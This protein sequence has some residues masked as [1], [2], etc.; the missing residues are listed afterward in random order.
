LRADFE[1][2][3]QAMDEASTQQ[4]RAWAGLMRAAQDG[5]ASAYA[6][7][8]RQITPFIRALARR[9]LRDDDVIEDA[10]QDVL[11][12]LHR[13]RGSYDPARPFTP[14]LAAIA[15]RRVIDALRR[16]VRMASHETQDERAYETFAD[17]RSNKDVE[18]QD[19]ARLVASLVDSLPPGQ[20]QALELVKLKE[21]SLSEAA[22]VSGQSVGGLKVGVHRAIKAL[23]A[24]L[25]IAE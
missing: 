3:S 18:A 2:S 4:E 1:V 15:N 7:L 22:A 17:P 25:G 6:K 23:R 8:L 24:R 14:W 16:R 13:A 10:V 21:M 12:T 11:L 9:R 5:E 19:A 20:R